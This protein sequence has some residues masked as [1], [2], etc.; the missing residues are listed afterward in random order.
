MIHQ[1]GIRLPLK[2][3]PSSVLGRFVVARKKNWSV[4][5]EIKQQA[6]QAVEVGRRE[7]RMTRIP[8]ISTCDSWLVMGVGRPPSGP[9]RAR[10]CARPGVASLPAK[11]GGM[12]DSGLSKSEPAL[13]GTSVASSSSAARRNREHFKA[14]CHFY[15]PRQRPIRTTTRMAVSVQGP[16]DS[17][18]TRPPTKTLPAAARDNASGAGGAELPMFFDERD[19]ATYFPDQRLARIVPFRSDLRSRD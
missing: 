16:N 3:H 7:P 6:T 8:R 11:T 12:L 10:G 13:R 17:V 15:C 5:G 4:G 14:A 1:A 19:H 2:P 9:G 18:V